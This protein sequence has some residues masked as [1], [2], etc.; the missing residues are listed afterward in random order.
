MRAAALLAAVLL[1]ALAPIASAGEAA[2][3]AWTARE[4]RILASL[5]QAYTPPPSRSNRV[6]DDP[7]AAALGQRIFFDPGFSATGAIACATCHQPERHFTDGLARSVVAPAGRNA[8]TVVGSAYGSWF[9]WDGRRDSLWAQ[10]LVPLEASGEI[11]G[12]RTGVVQR[13]GSDP[14]YRSDYEAIF[15]AFP[16]ALLDGVLAPRAGP[17]GDEAERKAW[18]RIPPPQRDAIDRVYANVGKAVE[19]FERTLLPSDSRFDRY[20]DELRAGR[21]DRAA[22]QLSPREVAGLRLFIDPYRTQCMQ[23]HNGPQFTN[24]GFHNLGTGTFDGASRAPRAEGE[25]RPAETLDFGRALGIQAVLLDVFNCLG[26]YSDAGPDDCA[27]LRFLSRDA[28]IPLEGAF[29]TPSLRDVEKTAPYMHD[30][31]YATLRAVLGHY[32][33]PP[34][35][36]PHELRAL[37]LHDR[38]LDDLVQ[39]LRSLSGAEPAR[40]APTM[41]W[42]D[43]ERALLGSLR[44][45]ALPDLPPDPG[46]RAGDDPAAAMLGKALFADPALSR[47]GLVACQTCH[48]PE[49]AFTDG[50]ARSIGLAPLR[51]NAP[52]LLDIGY[53]RW[54][55]W[56][57]R[58]DSLWS[59]ALVPLEHPD[60]MGGSRTSVVH[61]VVAE[62]RLAALYRDAFGPAPEIRWDDVQP[63]AGPNGDAAARAAWAALPEIVRAGIDR[64]F[65]NLGK[66][67]AAHERT[68]HGAPS[69]FDAYVDAVL[70]GRADDAARLL[71]AREVAGLA[72]FI[73]GRSG[74]LS[75]HHGPR[76]TDGRFHNLG[77]GD[78]G[79]PR[80]DLGREAGR[81]LVH[82]FEFNCASPFGDSVPAADCRH[83]DGIW[84]SEVQV[85]LRGAF[86]TPGLRNLSA[87]APYMHDGRFATLDQVLEFYRRPP[88]K[89]V[90]KHELPRALDLSD[91]DID[92]LSR[93]LRTLD[94]R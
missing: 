75:C 78:L 60:E 87:T 25:R 72:L 6:A 18:F 27:E 65:A 63:G 67:L 44:W 77:T 83:L 52:S 8:P 43:S 35:E 42:S 59:Q 20:V 4:L 92:D 36:T 13:I 40:P 37:G 33:T 45:A 74:C 88:D 71:D 76:F 46:N 48:Q 90:T 10:A 51:R 7:R 38:E 30:G 61:R 11:G 29:K 50:R 15:G 32:N 34:P 86:R 41:T 56:D 53:E 85:L 69:R 24:G 84:A 80:E 54:L 19:A 79:T 70:A 82:N 12:S 62:P 17:L 47:N 31:R 49:R 28:H 58:A 22:Q 89:A 14:R 2:A 91:R 93:F 5:R 1:P 21:P 39:F 55:Y 3:P 68:L 57:G 9:T 26:P 94:S 16:A 64:A 23:C 81:Q 66:A 73:A